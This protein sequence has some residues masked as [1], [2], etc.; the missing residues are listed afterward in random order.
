MNPYLGDGIIKLVLR[1]Q[2]CGTRDRLLEQRR[3]RVPTVRDHVLNHA[4]GARGFPPNSY[5]LFV[6][7]EEMDLV[8]E[9]HYQKKY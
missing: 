6:A 3:L 5:L 1:R 2:E 9:H 7:A 8:P 4:T